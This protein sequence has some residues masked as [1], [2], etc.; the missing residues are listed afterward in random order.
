LSHPQ[1]GWLREELVNYLWR[2]FICNG[3]R[4]SARGEARMRRATVLSPFD[5]PKLRGVRRPSVVGRF[6]FVWQ[7]LVVGTTV[8]F[9]LTLSWEYPYRQNFLI[10]HHCNTLEE[11]A[12]GSQESG[13]GLSLVRTHR[14]CYT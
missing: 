4:P 2:V 3:R 1:T 14:T 5:C 13:R 10:Q 9:P 7:Q 6:C 11:G 12:R 8:R